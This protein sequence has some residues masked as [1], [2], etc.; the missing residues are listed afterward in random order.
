[1]MGFSRSFPHLYLLSRSI[2]VQCGHVYPGI[3]FFD[4]ETF[5]KGSSNRNLLGLYMTIYALIL[6]VKMHVCDWGI[7]SK[8]GGPAP[9]LWIHVPVCPLEFPATDSGPCSVISAGDPFCL[10]TC[11]W[12]WPSGTCAHSTWL[13]CTSYR[14]LNISSPLLD[15]VGVSSEYLTRLLSVTLWN[16][17][18]RTWPGGVLFWDHFFWVLAN[19]EDSG[20]GH[21]VELVYCSGVFLSS[22]A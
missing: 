14:P 3:Y 7:D 5:W 19:T 2:T 10:R 18:W 6:Q 16:K 9:P 1:M 20:Q 12:H 8:L 15:T 22:L 17:V 13:W 11:P 4:T 21:Q